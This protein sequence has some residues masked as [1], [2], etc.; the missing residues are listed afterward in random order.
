[1]MDD[2]SK[3]GFHICLWQLPYF[4]PHNKYYKELIDKGLYVKNQKGGLPFEDVVLDFSN[5]QTVQWYQDKIEGLLKIGVSAIK[6]D[7][8]EGAQP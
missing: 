6:G 1:M 3:D 5:P 2:L 8:G 4:T 7:F